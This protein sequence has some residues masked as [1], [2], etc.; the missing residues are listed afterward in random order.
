MCSEGPTVVLLAAC[1]SGTPKWNSWEWRKVTTESFGH[2]FTYGT[3]RAMI[4]SLT[5]MPL[6]VISNL[7]VSLRKNLF[8]NKSSIGDAVADAKDICIGHCW[9]ILGVTL[10]GSI[11]KYTMSTLPN[12]TDVVKVK[13]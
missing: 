2:G 11:Y 9:S 8:L 10:Y 6:R 1:E 3:E 7:I 13:L 5:K 12:E 4:C